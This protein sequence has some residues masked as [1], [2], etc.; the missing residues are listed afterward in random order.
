MQILIKIKEKTVKI[1]LLDGGKA[2]DALE[3]TE[4]H[5]LSRELLPGID[6]LLRRNNLTPKKVVRMR[7]ES[8]QNE[9]F[10]TTRLA[11][12]VAEVWDLKI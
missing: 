9:N 4:E 10:T 11:K 5:A 8:D 1:V 12:A 3:I 7:V 2:V 6:T